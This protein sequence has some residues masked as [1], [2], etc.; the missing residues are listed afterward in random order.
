[1]WIRSNVVACLKT[2][3]KF[4]LSLDLRQKNRSGDCQSLGVHGLL[5]DT[6]Y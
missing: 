1:M 2:V 3:I 4:R 6:T 5:L